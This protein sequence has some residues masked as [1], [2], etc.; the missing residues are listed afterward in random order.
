MPYVTIEGTLDTFEISTDVAI[1]NVAVHLEVSEYAGYRRFAG[2][3]EA[4]V[5]VGSSSS[6]SSSPSAGIQ[7]VATV[8]VEVGTSINCP[9]RHPTHSEP[10]YF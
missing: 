7:L 10:S 8:T 6:D 5:D 4:S 3:F 1:S 2:L 9:P